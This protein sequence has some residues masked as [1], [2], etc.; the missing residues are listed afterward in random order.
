MSGGEESLKNFN[1]IMILEHDL[2][3]ADI[4]VLI[5]DSFHGF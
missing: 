3:V 1:K 2:V 4:V 5:G